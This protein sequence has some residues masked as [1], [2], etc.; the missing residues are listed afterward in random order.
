LPGLIQSLGSV[1]SGIDDISKSF[2]VNKGDLKKQ[3]QN[4]QGSATQLANT[5]V[6][7]GLAMR[8]YEDLHALAVREQ[9]TADLLMHKFDIW[10]NGQQGTKDPSLS[11]GLKMIRELDQQLGNSLDGSKDEIEVEDYESITQTRM[12]I[13]NYCS[14]AERQL[15]TST[16]DSYE[17][18]HTSVLN[19]Q[20]EI[21]GITSRL[22]AR[23][24]AM[25]KL[26]IG[27]KDLV[28]VKATI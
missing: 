27:V 7:T 17:S 8:D 18:A 28:P 3:T 1:V 26:L 16:A 13:Q 15:S 19:I 9:T 23:F 20:S 22:D 4:L 2:I 10:E 5:L 24:K 21:G 6:K 11:D 14:Q 25:S 12:K